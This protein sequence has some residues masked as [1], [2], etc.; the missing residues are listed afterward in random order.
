MIFSNY[1]SIF[2]SHVDPNPSVRV[3]SIS[4]SN[5][6]IVCSRPVHLCRV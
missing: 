3:L 6:S 5:S 1:L 4:M 2:I